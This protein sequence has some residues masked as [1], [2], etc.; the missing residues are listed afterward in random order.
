MR[1]MIKQITAYVQEQKLEWIFICDQKD[2]LFDEPNLEYVYPFTL[3]NILINTSCNKFTAIVSASE[4]KKEYPYK[5]E[6][7]YVHNLPSHRFDDDEFKAWCDDFVLEND[8]KVDRT[9]DIA[10]EALYW[11]GAFPLEIGLLWEQPGETMSEKIASYRDNRSAETRYNHAKYC[12][13]LSNNEKDNL[14]EEIAHMALGVSANM[15]LIELEKRLLCVTKD[16]DF[17]Q[18]FVPVNPLARTAVLDVHGSDLISHIQKVAESQLC[19]RRASAENERIVK[20]YI[21][22][23]L[24]IRRNFKFTFYRT[25][26]NGVCVTAA[27]E[28]S[29]HFSDIVRFPGMNV[30]SQSTFKKNLATLFIPESLNFHGFDFCLW[31]AERQVLICFQICLQEPSTSRGN[32]NRA[33][34]NCISWKTFCFNDPEATGMEFYWILPRS[35]FGTSTMAF[36]D[37]IIILDRLCDFFP[38][39]TTT[40]PAVLT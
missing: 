4:H 23:L 9:S 1:E 11:T 10:I 22:T 30:S 32:I 38:S 20:L 29:I 33:H 39:I 28:R 7:W 15:I 8:V 13:S 19:Y 35:I 37:N 25:N 6:G 24:E 12:S 36:G 18:L 14:R 27:L 2:V 17:K 5:L 34:E 40:A 3:I 16:D 31:D 21:K 26:E